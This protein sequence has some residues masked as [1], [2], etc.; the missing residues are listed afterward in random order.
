MQRPKRLDIERVL[1]EDNGVTDAGTFGPDG[2]NKDSL[3]GWLDDGQ[4]VSE[5]ELLLSMHRR[6]K[7]GEG[8]PES[9][10]WHDIE[11]LVLARIAWQGI[12][13]DKG[14]LQLVQKWLAEVIRRRGWSMPGE[15]MLRKHAGLLLDALEEARQTWPPP[16]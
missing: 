14:R 6:I 8:R 3:R 12:P 7:G 10:P 9:V 4:R 5:A 15:T 2:D 11:C 1:T 13:P 16:E